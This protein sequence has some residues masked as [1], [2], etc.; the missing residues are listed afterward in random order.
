MVDDLLV[1]VMLVNGTYRL[2]T[3]YGEVISGDPAWDG[4]TG[5]PTLYSREKAAETDQDILEA[6]AGPT[7]KTY[8]LRHKNGRID[9]NYG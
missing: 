1:E 4:K 8:A 9:W 2:L 7:Q 6:V 3:E 5:V